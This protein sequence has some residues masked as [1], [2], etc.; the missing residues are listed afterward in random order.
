MLSHDGKSIVNTYIRQEEGAS[1]GMEENLVG[2]RSELN[3]K[4]KVI[5]LY[6]YLLGGYIIQH[7]YVECFHFCSCAFKTPNTTE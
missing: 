7:D 2:G 4:V 5:Q 1:G 3:D 6:M